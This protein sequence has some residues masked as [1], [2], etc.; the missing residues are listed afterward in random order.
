MP[1]AQLPRWNLDPI[2]TGLDSDG[3]RRDLD[4]L[5]SLITNLAA[6]LS[7][8]PA[9]EPDA[10]AWLTEALGR[11]GEAESLHEQL[12]SYAY[13]RFSV[14][15]G[16]MA[17]TAALDRIAETAVPLA[18]LRVRFRN[19]LSRVSGQLSWPEGYGFLLDEQVALQKLQMSEAEEQLAADLAR[20]GADA[21]SRLH[22]TVSSGL[23]APWEDGTRTVVELRQLA[24]DPDRSVRQRAWQTE[25]AAWEGVR[26]PLA[27]ALNGVKGASHTLNSRRGWRS[28]L[29]RSASQNRLSTAALDAMIAT[30]QD[31]RPLFQRYLHTKARAIGVDR[32][33]FYDLF[34]PVGSGSRAWSFED[35]M[36]FIAARLGGFD[37]EL[38]DFVQMARSN[39]WID[40]EPRP[41]KVGGAYCI[42]FPVAGE[43]RILAN[44][45]GSFDGMSTLAHELGHAWHSHQLRHLPPLQRQYPMTLAE[46]AS[47]FSETLV[48]HGARDEAGPDEERY[49]IEQFLQ[50][51][52]QVIID[53]LSRFLFE[54]RVMER[55]A[56][57]ELSPEE[58]C[59]LMR[60]AQ[61][62]AYGD[63]L[64][65]EQ[66]H[67]Y[68][69]AVKGHYYRTELAFYNFP[70]AFGQ[71]FGLGLHEQYRRQPDGFIGRYRALLRETGRADAVT[72]TA[73]AGFDIET[74][75]FWEGSVA[76]IGSLVDRFAELTEQEQRK[77]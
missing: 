9:T 13:S 41:G 38:G 3:F 18:G 75:D 42:D 10:G 76:A 45:D 33:A 27:A 34:A 49:L 48:F 21:W 47:I 14:D 37:P 71:L 16:D 70:Y 72:V 65:H 66:L 52:T 20:S 69:W 50:G 24:Y 15:T 62:E 11:L 63:G 46:T 1:G 25:C 40:A 39:Q 44:F 26:T 59:T 30:M 7:R 60:E 29:E 28:T 57:A 32:L 74:R 53:I 56:T 61:I 51:A 77:A 8:D 6:H 36:S 17:A 22:E 23:E 19:A 43:S 55:R 68:M 31:A 12:D 67:P 5:G 4:R 35:A 54:R 58:F 64:D 2:Y 73:R